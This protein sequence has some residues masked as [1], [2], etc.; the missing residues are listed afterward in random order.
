MIIDA[1]AAARRADPGRVKEWLAEQRVF[2]SSAMGDTAAERS[3]VARQ[4]EDL[5]ARAVWFEEFGRDANAEEAY[6]S[7]LDAS[8]V[9][10]GILNELY[11]RPNPPGGD[12]AT[13]I[14]YRRARESGKRVNVYVKSNAPNREGALSRFLDRVRFFV[15]TESYVN[16]ADLAQRVGRRLEALAAEAFSPWIKLG[17]FVFRADEIADA[18]STITIRARVSEEIS[19]QVSALRD[20][21]YRREQ[22]SFASRTRVATCELGG[23]KHTIRAG[24]ADEITVELTKVEPPRGDAMRVSTAGYTADDLVELGLRELFFGTPTPASLGMLKGLAEPGINV[25]EL[26]QA[27]DLPNEFAEAVVRLVVTEGLVGRGHAERLISFALGPRTG[28][29]RRL[30]LEWQEPKVY[31][32]VE[33]KRRSI[34]GEWRRQPSD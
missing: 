6:L 26:R 29:V 16:D 2:I 17:D 15:T 24:G 33:A 27:F 8:T 30:A 13:E 4:I 32:N 3:A 12:S 18:G 31:V 10:V 22:L 9:Y 20:N 5:G 28:D 1:T 19:H 21:P 34:E 14:E 11:G 7:E 25:A 23:A